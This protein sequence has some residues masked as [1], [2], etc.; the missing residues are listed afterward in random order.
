MI[1]M[2][3]SE[4]QVRAALSAQVME[5]MLGVRRHVPRRSLRSIEAGAN[6]SILFRLSEAPSSACGREG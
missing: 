5:D 1:H 4:E 3:A 6:L 2:C